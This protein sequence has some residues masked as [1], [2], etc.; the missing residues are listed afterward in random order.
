MENDTKIA[1]SEPKPAKRTNPKRGPGPK[2]RACRPSFAEKIAA[3]QARTDQ[4][5]RDWIA[6]RDRIL[7]ESPLKARGVAS[8]LAASLATIERELVALREAI[9]QGGPTVTAKDL[10]LLNSLVK[11]QCQLTDR[12]GITSHKEAITPDTGGEGL[13]SL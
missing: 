7:A 6:E 1:P 9:A 5:N 12:L 8:T 11:T 10:A 3:A 13:D 4:A 2:K